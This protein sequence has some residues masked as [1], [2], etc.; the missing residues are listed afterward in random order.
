[1]ET[2]INIYDYHRRPYAMKKH[3]ATSLHYDLRLEWNGVLLSWALPEGPSCRAGL[4][5]QAIEMDDHRSAYLEFEGLHETGPIMLW[6]LGVWEPCSESED[7]EGSLRK[8]ILRFTLYGERLRGDWTLTRTNTTRNS[9]PVWNLSKQADAFS[10][11]HTRKSV[12]EEWPRSV[13][14]GRSIQEIERDW[15]RPKDKHQRQ[16]KLFD[17]A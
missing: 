10:Y 7:M 15:K 6:D 11:Q 4:F 13:R 3:L 8:G 1:M 16:A 5:R 12:L 14:T 17:A 9:R 2:Q